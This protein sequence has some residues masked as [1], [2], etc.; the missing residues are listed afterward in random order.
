MGT[1][2]GASSGGA[3]IEVMEL[4]AVGA[5]IVELVFVRAPDGIV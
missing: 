2:A 1:A 5:Q 3:W 4:V